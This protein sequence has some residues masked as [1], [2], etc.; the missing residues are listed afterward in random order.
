MWNTT[1]LMY[2]VPQGYDK[3]YL[4][5]HVSLIRNDELL[6][7]SSRFLDHERIYL[8]EID[9]DGQPNLSVLKQQVDELRD[10]YWKGK[11][12]FV[13]LLN[14]LNYGF[15][16]CYMENENKT[17]EIEI[18]TKRDIGEIKYILSANLVKHLLYKPTL[19]KKDIN[20]HWDRDNPA[21]L[22]IPIRWFS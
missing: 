4:N 10:D 5:Y 17:P 18:V 11:F 7:V 16:V 20:P 6:L 9:L 19:N 3:P 2:T 21:H 8:Q 15:T 14:Q 22:E 1:Y 13:I 12:K